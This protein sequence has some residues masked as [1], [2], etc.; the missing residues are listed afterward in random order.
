MPT[1]MTN[2]ELREL[3]SRVALEV[4]GWTPERQSG[5]CGACDS[6]GNFWFWHPES[7]W[8][9]NFWSPSTDPTAAFAVIDRLAER[10]VSLLRL[11]NHRPGEGGWLVTL[12]VSN[13]LSEIIAA[14]VEPTAPLAI[15]VAALAAVAAGK[16]T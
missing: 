6:K 16:T 8:A 9:S 7:R 11:S 4:M 10:G 2:S 14:S 15:C 5:A 3:D 12:A 1:E 13:G